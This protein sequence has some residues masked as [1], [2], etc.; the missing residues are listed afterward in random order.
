MRKY[1]THS[2]C[3]LLTSKIN[4]IKWQMGINFV[5]VR[6]S[7]WRWLTRKKINPTLQ[8]QNNHSEF[9]MELKPLLKRNKVKSDFFA[10]FKQILI[11]H[12]VAGKIK[13]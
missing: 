9:K 7:V 3:A 13:I 6:P 4:K 1:G 11:K 10:C 5:T 2:L 8:R 12:S